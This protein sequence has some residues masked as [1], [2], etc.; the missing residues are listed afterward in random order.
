MN[1]REQFDSSRI[2][3]A[4]SSG[5]V[6]KLR[7]DMVATTFFHSVTSRSQFNYFVITGQQGSLSCDIVM[8]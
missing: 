2:N 3:G 1:N 5:R 4:F 7:A 8:G 6:R